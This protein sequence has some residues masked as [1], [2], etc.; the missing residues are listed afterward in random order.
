MVL[1]LNLTRDVQEALTLSA[2]RAGV[3]ESE[4]VAQLLMSHLTSHE[5]ARQ[6]PR[7]SI[8]EMRGLGAEMWRQELNG[9]DAQEWVNEE[10]D[11]W[12]TRP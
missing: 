5:T 12:S 11:N 4:Y 1:N 2:A 9:R 8:M 7:R 6:K 3:P 10:R